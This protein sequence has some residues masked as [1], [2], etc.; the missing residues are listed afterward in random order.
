MSMEA[1]HRFAWT[2]GVGCLLLCTVGCTN[3]ENPKWEEDLSRGSYIPLPDDAKIQAIER[4][5]AERSPVV[6]PPPQTLQP[7]A[8]VEAP[9][10]VGQQS[11]LPPKPEPLDPPTPVEASKPADAPKK[12]EPTESPKPADP[13][14][15]VAPPK[16]QALETAP[17]DKM[18]IPPKP[19]LKPKKEA[20][21]PKLQLPIPVPNE[22]TEP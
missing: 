6:P 8:P 3:S 13:P 7:S 22:D 16:P 9:P 1:S 11:E 17:A 15:P 14:E 20:P 18:E 12:T 10:A 21:R 4:K 2:I 5:T 19:A